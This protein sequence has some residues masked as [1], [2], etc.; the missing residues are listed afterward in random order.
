MKNWLKK[1][2]PNL[3]LL[4]VGVLL[5]SLFTVFVPA[6]PVKAADWWNESWANRIK[7]TFDHSAVATNMSNFPIGIH[8]DTSISGFSWADI[9]DDGD[10]VRFVDS[11]DAT[12]LPYEIELWDDGNDA[13]LW[14]QVPQIDGGSNTDFIYMYYGNTGSSSGEDADAVW[15]SNYVGVY[16]F[17]EA[18]STIYDSTSYANNSTAIA[19]VTYAQTGG[20]GHS[21]L[22]G[23]GS[24]ID[25]SD[26]TDFEFN[27]ADA[28]SVEAY[29]Y[30]LAAGSEPIF[31]KMNDSNQNEYWFG[32]ESDNS[33][34]TL[35][36]NDGSGWA[37]GTATRQ[38]GLVVDSTWEGVATT[39]SNTNIYEWQDGAAAS[40]NPSYAYSSGIFAG[41]SKAVIANHQGHSTPFTGKID[42]LRVS[43]IQRSADWVKASHLSVTEATQSYAAVEGSPAVTV[44]SDA[45]TFGA[46]TATMYGTLNGMGGESTVYVYFRWGTDP[47][48]VVG[49][50]T[51]ETARGS[52]G[53]FS[54]GLTGLSEGQT[55][56]VRAA[57]RFGT[58]SEYTQGSIV[59]FTTSSTGG[60]L[61]T[62]TYRQDIT[63]AKTTTRT[64]YPI[65][66]TVHKGTGTTSDEDIYLNDSSLSWPGS[67]PNDVRFTQADGTTE[68]DYYIQ[69]GAATVTQAVIWVEFPTISSSP[70]TYYIY[71]GRA[72]DTTTSNIQN[73]FAYGEDFEDYTVATLI[74]QDGWAEYRTGHSGTIEIADDGG[75]R[76]I[77][78]TYGANAHHAAAIDSSVGYSYMTWVK[79]TSGDQALWVNLKSSAVDYTEPNG[80]MAGYSIAWAA[81]ANT[82]HRM[83]EGDDSTVTWLTSQVAGSMA[84][85]DF[86]LLDFRYY[87]TST[88]KGF[89]DGT[90]KLSATDS[91]YTTRSHIGI[92]TGQ[93]SGN[94]FF[95]SWVAV[96]KYDAETITYGGGT[97]GGTGVPIMTTGSVSGI[98]DTSVTLWGEIVS[99]NTTVTIRGFDYGGD[100]EDSTVVIIPDTQNYTDSD[101]YLSYFQDM[102]TWIVANK[103]ALNIVAVLH[104]GDIV[105]DGDTI[106]QW[107]RASDVMDTLDGAD[108]AYLT[109]PGNH[110]YI[111]TELR[112]PYPDLDGRDLTNYDAYFGD[113]RWASYGWWSG[114]ANSGR[115]YILYES[116]GVPFVAVGLQ[117]GPTDSDLAWASSI[118]DSYPNRLAIVVTH[119]HISDSNTYSNDALNYIQDGSANGGQAIFD[120]FISQYPQIVLVV[121]GH[122]IGGDEQGRIVSYVGG[123]PVNQILSNYQGYR[124]DGTP[125]AGGFGA[126]FLRYYTISPFANTIDAY[127]YSPTL[128]MSLTSSPHRFTLAFRSSGSQ[129]ES[130]AYSA[131]ETSTSYPT[132]TFSLPVS[133][134]DPSVTYSYRVKSLN[135][136]GWGYGSYKTFQT[137]GAPTVPGAPPIFSA[138]ASATQVT[139]SW[140]KGTGAVNTMVRYSTG[141]YPT[142]IN[143]GEQIY[144]GTGSTVL[145]TP[146]V[147]D[148]PH[149]YSAWSESSGLYSATYAT[150]TAVLGAQGVLP[151]SNVFQVESVKIYRSYMAAG[152]L[153][154]VMSNQI[155]MDSIPAEEVQDVVKIQVLDGGTLKAQGVPSYWGFR[156]SSIYLAPGHSLSWEA[157]YSILLEGRTGK[158]ASIPTTTYDLSTGSWIDEDSDHYYLKEWVLSAAKRME[159][160]YGNDLVTY[161]VDKGNVLTTEGGEWFERAI[162]GLREE[163][164]TLFGSGASGVTIYERGVVAYRGAGS[165]E[166]AWGEYY[167]DQLQLLGESMGLDGAEAGA[168]VWS[169]FLFMVIGVL[170][171]AISPAIGFV[172]ALPLVAAGV[173]LRM[174]DIGDVLAIGIALWV[175]AMFLFFIGRKN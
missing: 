160:Y 18:S 12:A 93:N 59:S 147:A 89:D 92:G 63:V 8:L 75:D 1:I 156:P 49:T 174:Y 47:T 145:H 62:Y 4:M 14:V 48:L 162:P 157:P 175:L 149:Y 126:G 114:E 132:G 74:G 125:G 113:G 27:A 58:P 91:T 94:T 34:G 17:S 173:Y 56:Y 39:V 10:D 154:I 87:G 108:I 163:V 152:D 107:V 35:V 6:Q 2:A 104:V 82:Y 72:G 118:L 123:E 120:G 65:A 44:T 28:F 98:S 20:F 164:P 102:V 106:A 33:F 32:I 115:S 138:S 79:R 129:Y 73:T 40:P 19:S 42:E 37:T 96:R 38:S 97:P 30:V 78:V 21:V 166:D 43:K 29:V 141:T 110:D 122:D 25:L 31:T 172:V 26:S 103:D 109:V 23:V 139:L 76:G 140:T 168:I 61:G 13:W 22:T 53:S 81:Y 46:T 143:T 55:Y 15:D 85:N 51:T 86:H 36:D 128:D 148:V 165:Q 77:S 137:V 57:A 16:H 124:V 41:T 54:Q 71:Y 171:V 52:T 169:I 119:M 64:N 155:I 116:G 69:E 68:I 170:A 80:A 133:G 11:D 24:Y 7:I 136:E 161:T 99:T 105:D 135:S 121:N 131:T 111:W 83:A 167:A 45:A 159:I 90:E 88:L 112:G 130:F 5:A 144:F 146:S 142:T 70:T 84:T 151:S 3:N 150:T 100:Y 127:T 101:T 67:I 134:L 95:I 153:L 66:F 50:N 9:Q 117:F 158:W 60:W